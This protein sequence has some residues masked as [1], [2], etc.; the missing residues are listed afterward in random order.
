M[1]GIKKPADRLLHPLPVLIAFHYSIY[2][3]RAF[4]QFST[5]AFDFA[6]LF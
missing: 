5:A 6:A 4:T 1:H 2:K 3:P